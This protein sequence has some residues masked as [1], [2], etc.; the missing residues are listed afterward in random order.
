MLEQGVSKP[1]KSWASPVILVPK[2]DENLQLC[3]DYGPL[4]VETV[5]ESYPLSRM[6]KYIESLGDT[7][8]FNTLDCNSD[9]WQI[10][11]RQ[12]DREKTGLLKNSGLCKYLRMPFC[13]T[14]A[15]AKFQ[16]T[17]DI[18]L[19]SFKRRSCLVYLEI[20]IIYQKDL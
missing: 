19:S 6:D 7:A 2:Q 11:V 18:L 16:C 12:E 17:L 8:M 5:R 10:P 4:N 15:P 3:V 14:N 1:H 9:Y 13:L 20:F